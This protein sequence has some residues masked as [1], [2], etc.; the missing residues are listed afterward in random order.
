[1]QANAR[2]LR[3][4]RERPLTVI[5]IVAEDT[6]DERILDAIE[7]K[8]N[9]QEALMDAVRAIVRN[10]GVNLRVCPKQQ[11]QNNDKTTTKQ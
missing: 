4:G 5:R 7:Q 11:R 6:I 3:Q 10:V 8:R 1:M 2:L 9:S